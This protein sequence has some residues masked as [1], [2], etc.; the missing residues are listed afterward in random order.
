MARARIN[1]FQRVIGYMPCVWCRFVYFVSCKWASFCSGF[2]VPRIHGPPWLLCCCCCCKKKHAGIG[3]VLCTQTAFKMRYL[4]GQTKLTWKMSTRTTKKIIKNIAIFSFQFSTVFARCEERKK[5][6]TIYV[7]CS[8]KAFTRV[9]VCCLFHSRYWYTQFE[10]L[11]L[12]LR[13]KSN[14]IY[15][16]KN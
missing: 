2:T 12:G 3:L 8:T 6:N 1:C 14:W 9:V 13:A 11:V 16:W 7:V 5:L 4:N 15:F 10:V